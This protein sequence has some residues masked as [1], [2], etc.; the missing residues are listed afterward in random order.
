MSTE[1]LNRACPI[2]NSTDVDEKEVQSKIKS[3]NLTLEELRHQTGYFFIT[4]DLLIVGNDGEYVQKFSYQF[5]E[6]AVQMF[7]S[8]RQ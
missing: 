6:E 4:L 1:Y 7:K 2:C 3:E 5:P 8:S